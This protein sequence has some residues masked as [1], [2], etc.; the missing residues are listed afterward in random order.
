VTT[1]TIQTQA[2][3]SGISLDV[4]PQIDDEGMVTLHIRPSVSQVS[5]R[6]RVINLGN[7]GSFTLPLAS[8]NINEADTV[9]RVADGVTVAIGGLMSQS[10]SHDDQR[11]PLAGDVPVLGE[12]FKRVNRQLVKREL[13]FLLKPTVIKG[14][15]QWAADL[16]RAEARVRALPSAPRERLPLALPEAGGGGAPPPAASATRD[17]TPE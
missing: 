2:F 7:L 10:Q 17:A 6:T 11:V 16:A 14:D 3:F 13:V 9:V 15:S 5:E 12:A 8:A 4:T 1:P